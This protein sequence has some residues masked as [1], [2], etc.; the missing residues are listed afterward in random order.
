MC[1]SCYLQLLVVFKLISTTII[2]CEEYSEF[3]KSAVLV[4][5]NC[6][7]IMELY[8]AEN[9]GILA[10]WILSVK[11]AFFYGPILF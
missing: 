9:M 10:L 5:R 3:Y 1:V 2:K 8:K 7:D 4:G 11:L 6:L